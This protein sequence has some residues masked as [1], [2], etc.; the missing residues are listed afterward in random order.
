MP[1]RPRKLLRLYYIFWFLLAYIIAALIFWYISLQRQNEVIE[2]LRTG[3]LD[4]NSSTYVQATEGAKKARARKS[5][6]YIGEGII[7]FAVIIIGAGFIFRAVRRQLRQ[8]VQQQNFMMGIT[9]ELKTPIAVSQLNLETLKKHNLDDQKRL[10]LL[11]A[12]LHEMKRLDTL[13]NNMLLV[14]QIDA[15]GYRL[16]NENLDLSRLIEECASGFIGRFPEREIYQE[17]QEG[18]HFMGDALLWRI[19]LN[20]LIDNAIKYSGKTSPVNI[21]LEKTRNI[22]HISISDNGPGIK[23]EDKKRVFEKFYRT[24]DE[25]TKAAKGTGLGL[26]L[27]A[28]VV[29][30]HK[31][32]IVAM[33]NAPQGTVFLITLMVPHER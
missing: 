12:T 24:G 1:S 29:K 20:N 26:Y 14:S 2:R 19:A 25:A 4:P 21:R 15:G 23:D 16:T 7:F 8:S 33:D 22:I 10:K 6:Q 32:K 13:S 11:D 17:I 9:H 31:G 5:A 30:R 3:S 18:V 27:T 28:R